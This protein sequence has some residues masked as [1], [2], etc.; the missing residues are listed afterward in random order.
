MSTTSPAYRKKLIEVALPLDAINGASA[1]EKSIRHGHP[2]TLHL[3]WARRPLAAARAVLFAQLVDDPSA[4]PELFPTE[5]A[6]EKERQR[7]FDIIREFVPWEATNKDEKLSP[8]RR[9]I[10]RSWAR[11]HPSDKATRVLAEDCTP[12]EVNDYLATELPPVH[13]PFAGGG[14]IPLEAQRLGLRAIATDLNPVAVLINKALIEIP[15]RFAGKLPVNPESRKTA[16]IRVWKGAQ[17]LAEDV[18]FYGA[19]MREEAKK[20]I[21][22]LY[23]ELEITEEMTE[24]RPDL[25]EHQGKK[26]T[27]IAWI[28]ARTVASPNPALGGVHIPLVTSYWL[29]TK[30]GKL[31]WIDP[32]VTSNGK[33][34]RFQIRMGLPRKEAAFEIGTKLGRGANFRCLLSG[35]PV[36]SEY[37]KAEGVAGRMGARLMAVVAEGRR[38]RVYLPPDMESER[39]AVSARPSWRPEQELP[40]NPRWFSPPDYGMPTYGDLFTSR[41]LVTLTAFSDLLEKVQEIAKADAVAAGLCSGRDLPLREGGDG[42]IAYG[43]ALAMYLAFV[44]DKMAESAT[45]ICTWSSAAKNELVV[46]TFR[47]QALPMTWDY[48]ETNPFAD[49]SGGITGITEYVAKAI[50]SLPATVSATARQADATVQFEDAGVIVSTDPPYY[51]NIGYADLSDFFYVWLRQNVRSL[52]PDE[53]R[54]LLVPKD[55]ELVATPY[56]HG[57]R[58]K[59]EVFFLEGMTR[60]LER[61]AQRATPDVPTTIYYAFKQSETGDAGT[62]STGWETFLDAVMA[63]GFLICGTWPVRT[64][65]SGRSIEIG[66][67]ALASSVVLVCR[68]RPSDAAVITR[69]DFRRLMRAELPDAVKALQHGNIAPVDLA[70]ASIGPGMAIF[71]RHGKVIEADGSPMTVR[72]ALQLINEALDEYLSAQEGEADPDTRFALTWFETNNWSVGSFGDAETLAKARNISVAGIV[73]SGILHSAVG[74]VRLLKRNELPVGWDPRQ[75]ARVPVWEATQHLIR[76][77]E[78]QGEGG[79]A[80]LHHQLGPLADHVHDLAYRLYSICERKGWAEDARAYNGLVTAWPEILRLAAAVLHAPPSGPGQIRLALVG[81]DPPPAKKKRLTARKPRRST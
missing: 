49:S 44:I 51:D 23:P 11:S 50:A 30:E 58:E 37:V 67:N 52:F 75:D 12:A 15:P 40:K 38:G 42:P 66:T 2:S 79:A 14:T 31:T 3:W 33:A 72:S 25:K 39:I 71:S 13:D 55:S 21:G 70:Q 64:E 81:S 1:R 80:A 43:E 7:L 22:K 45:T 60:A 19:W 56:R 62:A 16:D 36:E 68:N 20:R 54:T 27:V 76:R 26:L 24:E 8:A 28:W 46:S 41:Q 69:G 35:G 59:A 5:E 53:T 61:L 74:K 6:Q 78:E 65:R 10:A 48:A 17:G 77:L 18:R 47:R 73:E 57:G 29:S 63:A 32:V 4:W 34:Y 9:E